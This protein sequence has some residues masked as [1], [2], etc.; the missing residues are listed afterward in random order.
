M[1]GSNRCS[2]EMVINARLDLKEPY[3]VEDDRDLPE[4]LMDEIED[5]FY[6]KASRLTG[7]DIEDISLEYDGDN[8]L[9]IMFNYT[10]EACKVEDFDGQYIEYDNDPE[11]IKLIQSS[12]FV[13]KMLEASEV[14]VIS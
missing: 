10:T 13:L 12:Y 14:D 7:G 5:D 9:D 3:T 2:V 1:I 6:E 11:D 8:S 4:S